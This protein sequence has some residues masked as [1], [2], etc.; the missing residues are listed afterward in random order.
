MINI[1]QYKLPT[2]LYDEKA[3]MQDG[4]MNERAAAFDDI[5]GP[6]QGPSPVSAEYQEVLGEARRRN[7]EMYAAVQTGEAQAL[8]QQPRPWSRATWQRLAELGY[9]VRAVEDGGEQGY[10]GISYSLTERGMQ[11]LN[12]G[13]RSDAYRDQAGIDG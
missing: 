11:L 10:M 5:F 8:V 9:A 12:P 13:Y 2:G 4:G 3:I 1:E 6:V 7:A